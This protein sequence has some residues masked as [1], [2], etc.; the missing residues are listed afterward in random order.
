MKIFKC[1][2]KIYCAKCYFDILTDTEYQQLL[3]SFTKVADVD[4]DYKCDNCNRLV[5]SKESLNA[6]K[7]I[8]E[9]MKL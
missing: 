3:I 2:S 1:N 4:N 7:K 6:F 8:V 9:I 5:S